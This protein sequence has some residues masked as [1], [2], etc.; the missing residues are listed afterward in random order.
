MV[1]TF[2]SLATAAAFVA[3]GTPLPAQ[4]GEPLPIGALMPMTGDLQAYGETSLNGAELAALQINEQG[5]VLGR[6]LEVVIGDT[7]TRPQAGIDAA[8]R[9]V[10]IQGVF[11]TVGALSSGVSIPVALSVSGPNGVPQVSPAST[12]PVITTLEDE[13]FMF[14]SVPSDAYQGV[15]LATM[16]EEGGIDSVSILYVNN[17]Y[18]EGLANAFASN[19]QGEVM[20]SL[21]Y[22]PGNA[23]YRGELSRAARGNPQ[24]LL[25]IGYPENGVTILRQAIE[26]GFFRDFV[27]TD[28]LKAPELVEALGARAV[29]GA[30]GSSP[31]ALEDSEPAAMFQEAYRAEFGEVPPKPYIDTAYDG[32][33]LLA[34][35]AEAAG[36]TDPVA[37]RDHLREVAN[38]PGTKIFPGQWTKA[39]EVLQDGGDVDYVGA[40][41]SVNFDENGDVG[42]TFA[43]WAFEDGEIVVRRVM[44]P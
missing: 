40:S 23:S 41:G 19:Y 14:R 21:A 24:A 16:V 10:N 1:R 37:V 17:D 43:E 38:P 12:S 20:E 42:G 8:Q 29:E 22:E 34:L 15:A 28:G 11:G 36:S 35:A 30:F 18:G 27:F 3:G 26:E 4:D 9:L 44:A 33:Y 32:V 31:Q 39:V 6:P 7:Q 25:L 5:G 2:L 13:D